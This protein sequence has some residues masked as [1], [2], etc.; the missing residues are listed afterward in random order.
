MFPGDL[1]LAY[2]VRL[3]HDLHSAKLVVLENIAV[4]L[5]EGG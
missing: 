5:S 1:V 2:D 4:N 3:G